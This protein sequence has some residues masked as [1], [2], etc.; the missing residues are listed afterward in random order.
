[1]RKT[2]FFL[3]PAGIFGMWLLL[4]QS[5]S[6][7]QALLA[8]SMAALSGWLSIALRRQP[9][10]ARVRNLR[11]VATLAFRVLLDIVRSNIAVARIIV[12]RRRPQL[13]SGFVQIPIGMRSQYGLAALACIITATPGT[14]WVKFDPKEG[15]LVIHVLDLV[16]EEVW[17]DTIKRRYESLLL[18]IV[19]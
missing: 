8:G 12:T 1:M 14:V 15:V 9:A 2:R 19:E 13:R 17:I 16:D 11:A 3:V 10:R 7:G 6:F 4:N 5:V 18:E